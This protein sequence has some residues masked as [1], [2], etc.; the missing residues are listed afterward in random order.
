M[1]RSCKPFSLSLKNDAWWL[2]A[3]M[4]SKEVSLHKGNTEGIHITEGEE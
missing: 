1:S 2:K 3:K 4:T